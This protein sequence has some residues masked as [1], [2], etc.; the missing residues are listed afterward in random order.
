MS[1]ETCFERQMGQKSALGLGGSDG[2]RVHTL[3]GV[4][5]NVKYFKDRWCVLL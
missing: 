1:L 3:V 2:K 4:E 5:E